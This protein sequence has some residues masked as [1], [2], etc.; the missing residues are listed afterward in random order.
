MINKL[1]TKKNKL[2]NMKKKHI[3]ARSKHKLFKINYFRRE[4]LM[5]Y[6]NSIQNGNKNRI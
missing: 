5:S 3:E 1:K 4:G 6:Y 2:R